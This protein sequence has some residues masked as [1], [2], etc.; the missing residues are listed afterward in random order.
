MWHRIAQVQV[1]AFQF[2]VGNVSSRHSSRISFVVSSDC[3]RN[4]PSSVRLAASN[5]ANDDDDDDDD[6]SIDPNSL[7][8]WRA[9]RSNLANSGISTPADV[10][11][12]KE[13][14]QKRK[15]VSKENE[16]LLKRQNT[17]LAE[18]YMTGVWAHTTAEV[19]YNMCGVLVPVL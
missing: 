4:V 7:G 19:G 2:Q 3:H 16:K 1:D 14:A 6:L 13:Q 17:K 8:D 10:P 9:F 15:S 18:E 5:F 11:K 12:K